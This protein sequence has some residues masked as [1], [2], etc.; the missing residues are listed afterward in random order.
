MP[1]VKRSVGGLGIVWGT[2]TAT[3]SASGGGSFIFIN[4]TSFCVSLAAEVVPLPQSPLFLRPIHSP[5]FAKAKAKAS[6]GSQTICRSIFDAF[7]AR[8]R[9]TDTD[10]ERK[11]RQERVR[12]R[13]GSHTAKVQ[14]TIE[15]GAQQK[16]TPPNTFAINSRQWKRD[17]R[18]GIG[19]DWVLSTE[20]T[21]GIHSVC[22]QAWGMGIP[23]SG[24]PKK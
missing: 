7:P 16:Q 2:A 10:T 21:V 3:A 8:K 6:K 19:T 13:W 4:L 18:I 24:G 22:T 11:R 12:K 9:Q 20:A 5:F 14:S 17:R 23:Y 15:L 1:H